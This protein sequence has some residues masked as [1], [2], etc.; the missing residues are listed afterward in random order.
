[1]ACCSMCLGG[2]G[3]GLIQ[4]YYVWVNLAENG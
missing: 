3:G 4:L 1:M 2:G